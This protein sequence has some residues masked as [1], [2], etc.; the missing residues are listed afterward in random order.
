MKI[1]NRKQAKPA[2]RTS[3]AGNAQLSTNWAVFEIRGRAPICNIRE[4]GDATK[5]WHRQA[6]CTATCT[7][8][9]WATE[10]KNHQ[11]K[12][13]GGKNN[14]EV[15]TLVWT[16]HIWAST[17]RKIKSNQQKEKIIFLGFF[18]FW[19]GEKARERERAHACLIYDCYVMGW[20]RLIGCFKI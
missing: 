1:P 11:S 17:F 6:V 15:C 18:F 9:T 20:L 4:S 8:N 10:G 12:S 2:A 19:E 13:V 14:Q 7:Q 16:Q 5:T 3:S